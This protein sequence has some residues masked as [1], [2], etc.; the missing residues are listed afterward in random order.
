MLRA[1]LRALYSR[2]IV[3]APLPSPAPLPPIAP[4]ALGPHISGTEAENYHRAREAAAVA[5]SFYRGGNRLPLSDAQI[6]A[7]V[8]ALGFKAPTPSAATLAAVRAV[9]GVLA[10]DPAITTHR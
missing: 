9:L 3:I 8:R 5:I 1:V 4:V 7:R 10:A 2:R 6:T